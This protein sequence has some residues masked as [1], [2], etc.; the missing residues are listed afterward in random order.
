MIP[1]GTA[2]VLVAAACGGGDD[3]NDVT[4][5]VAAAGAS[6]T[7]NPTTTVGSDPM[8]PPGGNGIA[9]LTVGDETYEFD[10][11]YC[12]AGPDN[13]GNA[14]VPFSSGAMGTVDGVRV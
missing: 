13:T 5:T 1:I 10:N 3:A 6:A 8:P 7:N 14:W 4:S 2:L 11:C 12:I 9:T